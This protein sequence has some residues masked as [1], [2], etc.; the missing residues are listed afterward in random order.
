L[1]LLINYALMMS[2]SQ[3]LIRLNEL[4]SEN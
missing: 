4:I 2:I 3:I 1:Q